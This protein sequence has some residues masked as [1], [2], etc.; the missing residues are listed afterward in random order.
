MARTLRASQ[1][2]CEKSGGPPGTQAIG[3]AG[4]RAGHSSIHPRQC[5]LDVEHLLELSF[6]GGYSQQVYSHVA[7]L[8]KM[9]SNNLGRPRSQALSSGGLGISASVTRGSC[10]MQSTASATYRFSSCMRLRAHFSVNHRERAT[11]AAVAAIC[12]FAITRQARAARAARMQH[13]TI[14]SD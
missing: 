1:R 8:R 14:P 2:Q 9:G 10:H 13:G 6:S 12:T 4:R 5:T 11:T 3:T 7:V